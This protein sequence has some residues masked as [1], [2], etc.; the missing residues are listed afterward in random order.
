MSKFGFHRSIAAWHGIKLHAMQRLAS[1]TVQYFVLGFSTQSWG[2]K[3]WKG[4]KRV[5]PPPILNV[6]GRLKRET[7][8]ST[9]LVTASR[10]VLEN[11]ATDDRGRTYSGYHN[12]GTSK[13]VARPFMKQTKELTEKQLKILRQETGKVW[14]R[15]I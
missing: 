15:A 13:M 9:K 4:V 10:V 7:A 5:V 14:H 8:Q 12:E 3:P 11:D 1:E 2:S 6:T